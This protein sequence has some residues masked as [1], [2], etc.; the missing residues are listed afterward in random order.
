MPVYIRCS[1]STDMNKLKLPS[2]SWFSRDVSV[3]APKY[4]LWGKRN[5]RNK[6]LLTHFTASSSCN[7]A[8]FFPTKI[9]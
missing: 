4:H 9:H 2:D 6:R 8:D 3:Q 1:I 7:N 5:G